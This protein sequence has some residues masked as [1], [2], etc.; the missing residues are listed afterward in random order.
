MKIKFSNIDIRAIVIDFN[1]KILDMRLTNIFEI[2]PKNFILK[3]S[4]KKSKIFI[5]L[6]SGF[7]CHSIDKK[8]SNCQK[9]P[10]SFCSKLRK[11]LKNKRLTQIQQIG[12]DR[13]IDFTFGERDHT[14]HL[15]LEIV[16]K[17]NIVLTN[18]NYK[19]L[20]LQRRFQNI[21]TN[22]VYPIKNDIFSVEEFKE[23]HGKLKELLVHSSK[24]TYK[25]LFKNK[26]PIDNLG[27]ILINHY[28]NKIKININDEI[29]LKN[30][31]IFG[32]F[33]LFLKEIEIDL[34]TSHGYLILDSTGKS[35]DFTPKIYNKYKIKKYEKYEFRYFD[36]FDEMIKLY[37]KNL[38]INIEKTTKKTKSKISKVERV[39]K[40][41]ETRCNNFEKKINKNI[42][43]GE[44]VI[45]NNVL[46]QEIIDYIKNSIKEKNKIHKNHLDTIKDFYYSKGIETIKTLQINQK[47]HKIIINNIEID[48]YKSAY[49]NSED[50]YSNK[51]K[52]VVKLK[53]TRVEGSKAIK[54]VAKINKQNQT[55]KIIEK[56]TI[57]KKHYWFQKYNWFIQDYYLIIC[58]KNAQQN[59]EIVKKHMN[60]YDIYIHGDFHG[61]SSC[62]VKNMKNN[63]D[64]PISVLI[65]TGYFLVCMSKCW[66]S[67]MSE[68]TYFV[69]PEQ[70]SKSAP[71][72]EYLSV[73]SFMVKGKKNYL[74]KAKLE[75]GIGLMFIKKSEKL[76]DVFIKNPNNTETNNI[77]NTIKNKTESKN[78][79]I[80]C[81]PMIAPYKLLRNF[82]YYVKL[83]PGN[84]KNRKISKN[85][86]EYFLKIKGATN[87]EKF[88]IKNIEH[89]VFQNIIRSNVCLVKK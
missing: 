48:Y 8:P 30:L 87:L 27:P 59:E 45:E 13:I 24:I 88:L 4:N 5:K 22:L 9:A 29:T 18:K 51:K 12:L 65:N 20:H 43:K 53:K 21:K 16:S 33:C 26:T 75:L 69:K 58:G 49:K 2:N 34:I 41:I 38:N 50:Y 10:G 67:K 78:N 61:S 84:Q 86:M 46:I 1:K 63:D 82:K 47:K 83:K 17:G 37:F 28:L 57:I 81:L 44:F 19:I 40:D 62:I 39:K 23:W 77:D 3:F 66:K 52:L 80:C 55:H 42:S 32:K 54:K 68:R 31:K 79:L 64:I 7:R 35:V 6:V 74:P 25:T 36:S 14:F 89:D 15:I 72:G 76:Y 11:H 60:N 85:M 71:S 56:F 70:V 73:G